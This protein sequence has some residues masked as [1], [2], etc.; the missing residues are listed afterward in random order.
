MKDT[1][2]LRIKGKAGSLTATP[3]G[4]TYAA[5]MQ[6]EV[7]ALAKG[8]AYALGIPDKAFEKTHV[9]FILKS[10]LDYI[11]RL[12]GFLESMQANPDTPDDVLK[13]IE[14]VLR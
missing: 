6:K 10:T 5:I 3:D 4:K 2:N 11:E 1:I 14:R 9:E 7:R 12:E 8:W 13:E